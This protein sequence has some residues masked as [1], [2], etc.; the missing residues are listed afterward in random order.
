MARTLKSQAL[1]I[2]GIVYDA[3]AF[4][5][6]AWGEGWMWDDLGSTDQPSV[7]ALTQDVGCVRIRFE[8]TPEG[9]VPRF[10]PYVPWSVAYVVRDDKSKSVE[11]G[12]IDRS[13]RRAV[14]HGPAKVDAGTEIR[15][16]LPAPAEIA[17]RH[18]AFSLGVPWSGP[19][20]SRALRGTVLASTEHSISEILRKTNKSSQ[21]LGAECLLRLLGSRTG[22]SPSARSGLE[23]VRAYLGNLGVLPEDLRLVDG[24]GLSH[25]N[26]VSPETLVRVLCDLWSR[27]GLKEAFL[28]SLPISGQDGTLAGRMKG[29]EV[30][31]KVRAKT[32][33]LRGVSA[34]AGFVSCS[35]GRTCAFAI[36][37]E[38]FTGPSAPWR[39]LQDEFVTTLLREG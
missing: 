38:G 29:T 12:S 21:N 24:S 23:R 17:S 19:R 28:D 7:E 22:G 37:I 18:L 8:E 36:M 6:P 10:P 27:P 25:Y 31:G 39:E 20:G 2:S 34:L 33:T 32:G 4:E 5:G 14:L 9:T 26:L 13:E 1:N 30:A 3:T 16:A 35:S 11:V 15:V